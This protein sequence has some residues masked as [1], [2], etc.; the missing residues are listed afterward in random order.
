[1]LNST[2]PLP[3]ISL[4]IDFQVKVEKNICCG[5]LVL[6][7]G[8]RDSCLMKSGGEKYKNLILKINILDP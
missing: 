7:I 6:L 3:T 8:S 5:R 4:F 1:M 2:V